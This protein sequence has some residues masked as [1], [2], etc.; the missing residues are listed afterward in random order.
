MQT[1]ASMMSPVNTLLKRAVDEEEDRDLAKT[2][3]A[4][5]YKG[6]MEQAALPR[7]SSTM[8]MMAKRA[9]LTSSASRLVIVLVGLPGRGKSFISR[10]LEA[11]LNWRGARCKVFNVGRY[12]RKVVKEKADANFFNTDNAEGSSARE[13][14]A[15]LALDDLFAWLELPMMEGPEKIDGGGD[16]AR[17]QDSIAVFDA[18]NSTHARREM[19]KARCAAREYPAGLIFVESLCDDKGLLDDNFRLKVSSLHIQL[20]SAA[21]GAERAWRA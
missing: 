17:R 9:A 11:F 16:Y 5:Y 15:Q 13:M 14:V 18:T 8:N 7:S 4:L 12:R 2:P 6:S 20:Q 10:K 1:A 21:S 3:P 19:I